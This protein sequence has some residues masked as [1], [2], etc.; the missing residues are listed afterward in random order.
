MKKNTVDK[1]YG[2]GKSWLGYFIPWIV[3]G[4][5]AITSQLA[6]TSVQKILEGW[7]GDINKP[8][9]DKELWLYILYIFLFILSLVLFYFS[10]KSLFKPKTKELREEIN[11]L[12]RKCLLLG[13]I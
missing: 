7:V 1:R 11:P 3:A 6:A 12:K 10:S 2:E 8:I 5:V 9:I 4:S 13:L